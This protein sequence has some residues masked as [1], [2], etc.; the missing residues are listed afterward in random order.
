MGWRVALLL[1]GIVSACDAG[2]AA[3]AEPRALSISALESV[4][5]D[6]PV[7]DRRI[8]QIVHG[9]NPNRP[10]EMT[11]RLET[12]YRRGFGGV[13]TNVNSQDY[14]RNEKAWGEFRGWVEAG[15]KMG[16]ALWL[17]D[18]K[19]YPSASA[20]GITLE[21]HPE[22]E[23]SGLHVVTAETRPGESVRL[24]LPEG[25]VIY[26]AAFPLSTGPGRLQDAIDLKGSIGSDRVLRWDKPGAWRVFAFVTTRL[27]EFTHATSNYSE[28]RRYPNLLL[29]EPTARFIEVTHGEYARRFPPIP[30]TFDAIFTDEPSLMSVYLRDGAAYPPLP[31]ATGF[32]ADFRSAFG[33]DLVA[34]LP[35]LAA[36]FGPEGRRVRCDFWSYIGRR[37]ADN[38]FG[39]IQEWCHK[40]G[41][42]STGHL[43][44][45]EDLA[46]H[47]GFY[48]DFYACASR[49]DIPGID[50]LTSDP[51]G[52]P[53]FIAKLLGSVACVHGRAKVMSETSDFVQ[54]G[55]N[56]PPGSKPRPPVPLSPEQI[57]GA[58]NKLYVAGVNTTTSYYTWTGIDDN[59][60]RTINTYMGR[61]GTMLEGGR[62]ASDIALVYPKE[63]LWA[64]FVPQRR[65]ARSPELARIDGAYRAAQEA[66]FRAQRDFDILDS[67]AIAGA[68]VSRDGL[69]TG[70]ENYRALVLPAVNVLPIET[71]R[72]ARELVRR[73]G[74]V[75]AIGELPVNSTAEFPSAE[76]QAI[77]RE[78]FGAEKTPATT[79]VHCRKGGGAGVYLPIPE[80]QRLP[81]VLKDL[82]EP[83]LAAG[84]GS[85]I[86]YRHFRKAG[87]EFYFV[88]NDSAR[89]L[90]ETVAL[91]AEG[92][93]SAWNPDTGE[94]T[95]LA[96][97]GG[98]AAI[99][100]RPYGSVFLSLTGSRKP[101]RPSAGACEKCV[102]APAPPAGPR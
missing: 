94:V 96:A 7:N 85:A 1:A 29:K 45:E 61:I 51:A 8:L 52:M 17:Y 71:L 25:D 57:L 77:V 64:A 3:A 100:L 31:W 87:R 16:M 50:C 62:H 84:A 43:L 2:G 83:D 59:A 15:R 66:L 38:Y 93:A 56:V 69:S 60:M 95:A 76:A 99:Q 30:R 82:L 65:G 53:W 98:R 5:R 21:G 40:Q 9:G 20:G 55:L 86:R 13:V 97:A 27:Y 102:S 81:Q 63:S 18:E 91:R 101:R 24:T 14:L 44:A 34:R 78:L 36:D 58:N 19:G 32:D 42:A 88:I 46:S 70:R 79:A 22:W 33:Y 54:R 37:V 74:T 90:S 10:A 35:A 49:L 26:A 39:Q 68:K 80:V 92:R 23:A 75:V 89:S 11:S 28:N 6:P 12:L 72:R 48:G 47:V 73:G 4:F 67:A 41:V